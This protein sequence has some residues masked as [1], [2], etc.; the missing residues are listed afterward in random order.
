MWKPTTEHGGS[1]I[2]SSPMKA[3]RSGRSMLSMRRNQVLSM[4]TELEELD[5]FQIH[6]TEGLFSLLNLSSEE[7]S[8]LTMKFLVS[9]LGFYLRIDEEFRNLLPLVQSQKSGAGAV[10]VLAKPPLDRVITDHLDRSIKSLDIC[11]AVTNSLDM[12]SYSNRDAEIAAS[13]ICGKSPNRPQF[14]RAKNAIGKL[15]SSISP[16]RISSPKRTWSFGRSSSQDDLSGESLK[17]PHTE[18]CRCRY[19]RI[20]LPRSNFQR[21]KS[22]STR[23]VEVRRA[24]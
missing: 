23:H 14:N 13:A 17:Y 16:A 5:L 7:Y 3:I 4:E 12:L 1:S 19:P 6:V 21:W 20:G 15:L 2:F 10:S 24:H 22:I 9:L 18:R 8:L 11:T